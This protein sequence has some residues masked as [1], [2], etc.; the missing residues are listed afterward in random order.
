MSGRTATPS[1][2]PRP[3]FLA[4]CEPTRP[5]THPCLRK[6]VTVVAPEGGT[7]PGAVVES[8]GVSRRPHLGISKAMGP[9]VR[10]D[11]LMDSAS[12]CTFCQLYVGHEGSHA[13]L[14][15]VDEERLLRR[16]STD[17]RAADTEFTIGVAAALPWAPGCPTPISAESTA[18][19]RVITTR[20]AIAKTPPS[21][22]LHIA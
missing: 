12:G 19:L 5:C 10:C 14:V 3:V 1:C 18:D 15:L 8:V 22:H 11:A 7:A 20:R 17:R 9:H 6:S 16:W 4:G 13:A 2:G 21:G